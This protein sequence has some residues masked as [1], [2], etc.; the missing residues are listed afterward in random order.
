MRRA[1]LGAALVLIFVPGA[2]AQSLLLTESEALARLSNDSPRVRAIRASVDVA[3]VEVLAAGRWPN[4]QP[5]VTRESVAGVTEYLT[6]VSQLLPVTGRRGLDVNAASAMASAAS[7]R[8]DDELRRLRTDLRLAFADLIAA[9]TRERELTTALERLRIVSQALAQRELQGDAAGFDR[10]RAEREALDVESDVAIA[11]TDRARAQAILA[12]FFGSPTD[13]PQLVAVAGHPSSPE[14]PTIEALLDR[15]E[16]TRGELIALRHELEAAAFSAR[17]ADR[18]RVPEPEILAGT[19]SSSSG[20]GD[21]G[22][23]VSVRAA[24]PLFDQSQPER[25]LAAARTAQAEARAASFRA[26]LRGQMGALREAVV[27]RRAV[28]ARYRDEA[29]NGAGQIER[30]AQVAYDA[31]ERGILELLDAY[32]IGAAARIRQATLDLAVRQA[33]IEL[34][35]VS[36]WEMP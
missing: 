30:I 1:L 36:G 6:T 5:S 12:T 33:E 16:S 13:P 31:G 3:R 22:S 24:I 21:L 34:A 32:R 11:A 29:I 28:A 20:G 17:A 26:T 14:V 19:K 25:A 27:R 2:G 4:P 23:I 10:L 8:A 9:Q 7:S 35:F 15:A 18:R